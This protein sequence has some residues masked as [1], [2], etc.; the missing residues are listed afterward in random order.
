MFHYIKLY[1]FPFLFLG[2]T[3]NLSALAQKKS[4]NELMDIYKKAELAFKEENYE[5]ILGLEKRIIA[6]TSSK[7]DTLSSNLFG[8]LGEAFLMTG[9]HKPA[10]SYYEKELE[11]RRDLFPG[12]DPLLGDILSNMV[13]IYVEIG[14]YAQA[15]KLYLELIGL[16]AEQYGKNSE[17]Y[18]ISVSN[19]AELYLQTEQFDK[20]EQTYQGLLRST[21]Q[22]N[23]YYPLI[24]SNLATSYAVK[25]NYSKAERTYRKAINRI[26]DMEGRESLN[27]VN[28]LS[29]MSVIF[30]NTGRYPEA[31]TILLE[32]KGIL[33][34]LSGYNPLDYAGLF[35]NLGVVYKATG[36]FEEAERLYQALIEI[37]LQEYGSDHPNYAITLLNL[38]ALCEETGRYDEAENLYDQTLNIIERTFGKEHGIYTTALNN[39]AYLLRKTRRY[40]EAEK[41]FKQAIKIQERTMGKKHPEYA[42]YQYN[43]GQVY[44]SMGQYNKAQAGFKNALKLR[45]RL[46]S[47]VHPDYG[48]SLNSL[49]LLSWQQKDY[50][51]ADTF[52]QLTFDNFFNQIEAYFPSMSEQEKTRFYNHRLRPSF[53]EF[54]SYAIERSKEHKAILGD[55]YDYQL[56]T[57]AIIMYATAKARASIMNSGDSTLV[58]QFNTWV[59]QQE[60]LA[61]LYSM[62]KEDLKKTGINQDSL[63]RAANQL[64]KSLT[65]SSQ[66]FSK[67]YN[68]KKVSWK[69]VQKVLKEDEAAIEIIR[70]RKFLPDSSGRFTDKVHY[71]ALIVTPQTKNHPELVFIENGN[72]LEGRYLKNYRNAIRFRNNERFS[73]QKYWEPIKQKLHGVQKIYVSPD[74]VY[75]QISLNTLRN[76][77]TNTYVLE[78]MNV[79]L[80]TNTKDL[81]FRGQRPSDVEVSQVSH[82]FGFPDYNKGMDKEVLALKNIWTA[83]NRGMELERTLRGSLQ[84]YVRDNQ[85]LAMLPGTKVEVETIASIYQEKGVHSQTYLSELAVEEAIKHIENPRTLHIATHGFFLEDLEIAI[86]DDQKEVYAENPLLRSGLILAGANTYL[87]NEQLIDGEDGILTAYEAMN[88]NLDKTELVVLSACETGLGDIKNGEGVYGLQRAFQVAGAKS[89]I[90]S[91]WNV[92]DEA[93]QEL[94]TTFYQQWMK[95]GDKHQAFRQAQKILKEKYKEPFY[96]GAFV[97]VGE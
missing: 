92:D 34:K 2:M 56:N 60:T 62:N 20:C 7:K 66:A 23:P 10:L 49:A 90:M 13:Y 82:L 44:Y 41:L 3:A 53:E 11:I 12:R 73:Y 55:M 86:P 76:P 46:L 94:M 87:T 93:T 68:R 43:L 50:K 71:A 48:K 17:Q 61:R 57:K 33:D 9:S 14:K 85:L 80:A 58:D 40:D 37:D 39:K 70:F 97:M 31:E 64:E 30:I 95:T 32:A 25:G 42:R 22:N 28:T 65:K 6:L 21:H 26:L 81:I 89:V 96:W 59:M 5:Q 18:I 75:N 88:L 67:A 4:D 77:E 19:L 72:E 54:N 78:E 27:Y 51:K 15:E 84:R 8:W 91:L 63:L 1:L 47:P 24:L 74:G 16:D 35:N 29:S 38:G 36:Q 69:D 79:Q 52:F 45:K 83:E